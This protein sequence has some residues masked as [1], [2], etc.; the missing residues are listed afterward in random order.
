MKGASTLVAAVVVCVVIPAPWAR[1]EGLAGNPSPSLEKQ[2]GPA[3]AARDPVKAA[4]AK[5]IAEALNGVADAQLQLGKAYMNGAGVKEDVAKA[6][7]WYGKAA[8]QGLQDAQYALGFLLTFGKKKDPAGPKWLFKAAQQGHPEAWTALWLGTSDSAE[9]GSPLNPLGS[10]LAWVRYGAERKVAMA[11]RLLGVRFWEGNGVLQDYQQ[12]TIW[13]RGAAEQ[14][15]ADALFYLGVAYEEGKGVPQD[16]KEALAWYRKSAEK[17]N[18]NAQYNVGHSYSRGTGI[19]QDYTQAALWFRK[20]AEQGN[21]RAQ[22]ALGR[23]YVYGEGVPQ[24]YVEAH[25]WMNL[26]TARAE[27]ELRGD[28]AKGRDSL[29]KSMTPEQIAQA[30]KLAREWLEAFEK[31][32]K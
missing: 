16:P 4:D 10:E 27:A 30:Q 25:K 28:I 20:A 8:E 11:Q 31:R 26:A 24:D 17:G 12:A 3:K 9:G 13:F 19:T 21:S 18:A 14:G 6:L 2:A 22:Y 32:P 15:D 29:A 1:S 5:M 23:T 7:E